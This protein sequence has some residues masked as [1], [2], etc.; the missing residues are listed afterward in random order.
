[1]SRTW[2][3]ITG[4]SV[5]AAILIGGGIFAALRLHN[6]PVHHFRVIEEGKL[7]AGGQPNAGVV[8]YMSIHYKVKTIVN[9][10]GAEPDSEWYRVE[11][12]ACLKRGIRLIDFPLGE[13]GRAAEGVHEFLTIMSDPAAYPIYVHCE[14]GSVRTGLAVAVYRMCLQGW[15]LDKAMEEAAK[16]NYTPRGRQ[17]GEYQEVLKRLSQGADWRTLDS[18]PPTTSRPEL[19]LQAEPGHGPTQH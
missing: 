12:D 14:A 1:M 16:F 13:Q 6:W 7:Y 5:L 3:R 17:A 15:T 11:R 2:K 4:V 8:D 10:R 9:L 18:P 19:S